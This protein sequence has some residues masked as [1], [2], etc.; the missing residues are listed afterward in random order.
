MLFLLLGLSAHQALAGA[1]TGIAYTPSGATVSSAIAANAG[2]AVFTPSTALIA[3]STITLTFPS[4]TTLANIIA[5][6]FII[7]QGGLGVATAPSTVAVDNGVK[8]IALT[9]A[10]VSLNAGGVGIVTIALSGTADGDEI[11]EPPGATTTGVFSVATSVGDSGSINN[12]TIV[13]GALANVQWNAG[14]AKPAGTANQTITFDTAHTLP[15]NGMIVITYPA[16]FDVSAAAFVSA[17]NIDGPFTVGVSGQAVTVTRTGGTGTAAGAGAGKSV[18][19]SGINNK[20]EVNSFTVSVATKTSASAVIDTGTASKSIG[21]HLTGVQDDVSNTQNRVSETGTHLIKFTTTNPL[22]GYDV[23]NTPGGRVLVTFPDGFDVSGAGVGI[24]SAG[25]DGAFSVAVAGKTVTLTRTGSGNAVAPNTPVTFAIGGIV[26]AAAIGSYT[27]TVG[28][29]GVSG[30]AFIDGPTQSAAFD[31]GTAMSNITVTPSDNTV[32][33]AG[34]THAIAVTLGP[35]GAPQTFAT[36]S[37]IVITY[38][39]GFD[40]TSAAVFS[41]GGIDGNLTLARSGQTLTLTRSGGSATPSSATVTLSGIINP[42]TAS[43]SYTVTALL[44]NASGQVQQGPTTST[45]FTIAPG[46]ATKVVFVQQ[47]TTVTTL[48][49][50][51]P[52]ITVQLRDQYNNNVLTSGVGITLAMTTGTGMMGG[53]PTISTAGGL[54]TFGNI[55]VDTEGDK[56]L[57]ATS[58]TLTPAVSSSFTVVAQ[59]VTKLDITSVNAGAQVVAGTP[60]NVVVVSRSANNAVA[61]VTADTTVTLSVLA[62]TQT[63]LGG[64]LTGIIP[65]GGST[66]T[67]SGVTYTKAEAGVQLRATVTA[68]PALTPGDSAAFTV[69]PNAPNRLAITAITSPTTTPTIVKVNAPFSVAVQ[70]QDAYGNAVPVVANTGVQL[71]VKTGTGVLTAGVNQI[72]ATANSVTFGVT[73]SVAESGVVLSATRVSGDPLAAGDSSAFA[74][75]GNAT[76]LSI[77]VSPISPATVFK[78]GVP[79]RVVV[80][81]K[82]ANGNV[83]NVSGA[84]AITLAKVS[85]SSNGTLTPGTGLIIAD[86]TSQVTIA[87]TSFNKAD[88]A[89]VLSA[90]GLG[91]VNSSAIVVAGDPNKLVVTTINDGAQV[92]AGTGFSVKVEMRDSNDRSTYPDPAAD[93]LIGLERSAGTG[94]LGGTVAGTFTAPNTTLTVT[95]VTYTTA[96]SGVK[97]KAT[98]LTA[99][100]ESG[101]FTVTAGAVARL[102][103]PPEVNINNGAIVTAGTGFSVIVRAKDA[104]GNVATAAA[105][106]PVTLAKLDGAGGGTLGGTTTGTIAAGTSSVTISGVIF[107]AAGQNLRLTA[108]A[109]T[110]TAGNSTQF[111]V[112]GDAA[113]LVIVSIG[114]GITAGQPFQIVVKAVDA[115]D[116]DALVAAN[117]VLA[118]SKN[119]G[120]AGTLGGTLSATILAGQNNTTFNPTYTKAG[121]DLQVTVTD[122]T[123]TTPPTALTA[124]TSTAA[125]SVAAGPPAK[126]SISPAVDDPGLNAGGILTATPFKVEVNS[127]DQFGN[128]ANVTVNTLIQLSV[129]QG[130]GVLGGTINDLITANSNS[131]TIEGVTYSKAE[132]AVIITATSLAGATLTAADSAPFGVAGSAAK[133]VFKANS[134]NTGQIVTMA[135]DTF[136]VTVYAQDVNGVDTKANLATTFALSVKSGTGTLGGAVTG[137]IP[138][139]QSSVTITSSYSKAESGVALTATRTA[140]DSVSAGDSSTFAVAGA[141]SELAITTINGGLPVTAAAGFKVLVQVQDTNHNPTKATS[142][143]TVTITKTAPTNTVGAIAIAMTVPA[144]VTIGTGSTTIEV[145]GF[146]Q[147]TVESGVVLTATGGGL[148]AGNSIAFSI[149]P[150]AADHY[151]VSVSSP[152]YAGVPVTVTAQLTDANGNAVSGSGHVVTWTKTG[153][154]GIFSAGTSTTAANGAATVNFTPSTSITPVKNYTI[155]AK[156]NETPDP[157]TGTATAFPTTAGPLNAYQIVSSLSSFPVGSPNQLIIFTVDKFGNVT[158]FTG[159]ATLVFGG[160]GTSAS[161]A[162]PTIGNNAGNQINVGSPTIIS[163]LAG[164]ISTGGALIATKVEGP[165][166]ITAFQS[167][168]PAIST[169]SAGGSGPVVTVTAGPVASYS[170]TSS[171]TSTTAGGTVTITAQAIDANGNATSVSGNVVTWSSSN[172]GSFASPTSTTGANGAATVVFTTSTTPGTVHTVTATTGSLTGTSAAITT[173][174]DVD[175]DGDGYTNAQEII[176][177][178][179]PNNPASALR[180]TAVREVGGNVEVDFDAIAGKQYKIENKDALSDATW[181][182]IDS[183]TGAVTGTQTVVDTGAGAGASQFYRV[184]AG[185]NGEVVSDP[186]GYYGVTLNAGPNAISVPLHNLGGRRLVSSVSGSTVTVSGSPGWTANAFAPK[187]GFSQYIVLLRKDASA[188]PGIEGDWWTVA[189]NTGDTLTL[190]AG[191]DVLSSLL[192]SGDQIEIRRLSSMKDLFGTG[193]TLILNKDSDGSAAL[194]SFAGAD[195]IRF[196]S[197]TSFAQPI[198]YHDGTQAPA[199]YYT[200]AGNVGPLDGSTITVLPGQGFMVFRKTGSSA[201]TVLVNGQVQVS[202]LTEYLN[203]GPNVIGSPFAA[204]AP[205][206][207]SNLK[208]SGWVSDSDGSAALGNSSKASLLR[209]VTGTAFGSS[210]FHHDGSQAPAGWYDANGVLSNNFPLQPGRAYVFYITPGNAVR[211]RQ[212]VP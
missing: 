85:G 192:G 17:A 1:I 196:I 43:T 36:D 44:K 180:I 114:T 102:E 57:T 6:D 187:D 7:A 49:A 108:S 119:T 23:V 107:S 94:T 67:F 4:D 177:G 75:T 201:T 66:I 99:F 11:I 183:F 37:R 150:A 29:K 130:T 22:P 64:T 179:D 144:P 131:K 93:T 63:G 141:P 35:P 198:F 84:T 173:D 68:G 13:A 162:V 3:G 100:V 86:G 125:I 165:V 53:T 135:P 148:T 208:E 163:F 33:A 5:S 190:S 60:F 194:G 32:N 143:V 92:V 42:T 18:T 98:G 55:T 158:D 186:A 52:P 21:V 16:G 149:Q 204:A 30:N 182:Q 81:S 111:N 73:Y 113:K 155:T 176:A 104:N 48:T 178:T 189:S 138:A 41:L 62:G 101:A 146:L 106:I 151:V 123:T 79:F 121:T 115:A 46:V 159:S 127:E 132:T 69:N 199:G 164:E 167:G 168:A 24:G 209:L 157:L 51:S 96:E 136:T 54:A 200:Q 34:I 105:N 171:S 174:A 91:T 61:K 70:S 77:A 56:Q 59:P 117:R 38:P 9:V 19:L 15:T 39:G 211:W 116:T 210:V 147:A 156:G 126:L 83:A 129:K 188:S 88:T 140:G 175:S 47:P 87:G 58:G 89:L 166:T 160:L 118:L 212:A 8:T 112:A 26:N 205:I 139:G 170:V 185:P 40:V 193:T 65:A 78:S 202:R 97:V 76:Q 137:T 124:V 184:K 109:A 31:L 120:A 2:V 142:P 20:A 172:G 206:G 197:G 145:T 122:T 203:V 72:L 27:V 90:S 95:G 74:V 128:A 191:T 12:V 82:D 207:T 134:I 50:I 103:F 153:T 169:G 25:F 28:T 10:A 195:V 161:G 80:T 154:G 133:L 45:A 71:V 14:D 181:T 110:I 152:R